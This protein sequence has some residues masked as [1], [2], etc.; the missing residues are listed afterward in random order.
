MS[1]TPGAQ[2]K[3]TLA[4]VCDRDMSG[5]Q[6]TLGLVVPRASRTGALRPTGRSSSGSGSRDSELRPCGRRQRPRWM[7]LC[8]T[9]S[10]RPPPIAP[11]LWPR[12]WG[13]R[14]RVQAGRYLGPRRGSTPTG[15]PARRSRCSRGSRSSCGSRRLPRPPLWPQAVE[16]STNLFARA[17]ARARGVHAGYAAS[18]SLPRVYGS[19]PGLHQARGSGG[20]EEEERVSAAPTQCPAAKGAQGQRVRGLAFQPPPY[21]CVPLASD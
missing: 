3:P 14:R 10:P 19:I 20:W 9:A 18:P 15:R 11:S 2:P 12:A 4:R 16:P 21:Y 13:A 5:A 8:Y 17:R 1:R 7:S 6:G